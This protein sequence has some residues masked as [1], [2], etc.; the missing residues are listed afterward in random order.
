MKKRRKLSLVVRRDVSFWKPKLYKHYLTL[1]ELAVE[2]ERD[3]S[4]IRELEKQGRIPRPARINRGTLK[5]RLYSPDEVED[6]RAIL[7]EISST[8]KKKKRKPPRPYGV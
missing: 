3:P 8:P 6:I 4:W 5:I 1:S 2:V 7:E